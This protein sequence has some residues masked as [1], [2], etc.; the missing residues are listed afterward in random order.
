MHTLR[1]ANLGLYQQYRLG[2]VCPTAVNE[3][4]VNEFNW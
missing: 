4:G 1:A 2:I 3:H